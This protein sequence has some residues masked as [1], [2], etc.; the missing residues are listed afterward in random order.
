LILNKNQSD[1]KI[2]D[3]REKGWENAPFSLHSQG[4]GCYI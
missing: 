1:V 2:P 3:E 4:I